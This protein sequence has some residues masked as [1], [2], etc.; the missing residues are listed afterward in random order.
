MLRKE[1]VSKACDVYSFGIFLWEI[2][3]RKEPFSD[4]LAIILP[5]RIAEGK[6]NRNF[7]WLLLQHT[8]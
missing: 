5:S 3:T 2:L 6:V 4:I 8:L 1:P 7:K